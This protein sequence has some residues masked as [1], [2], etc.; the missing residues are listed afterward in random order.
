MVNMPSIKGIELGN[1][2]ASK[3]V[4]FRIPKKTAMHEIQHIEVATNSVT[5]SSTLA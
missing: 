5:I 4:G 3:P 2:V 1:P